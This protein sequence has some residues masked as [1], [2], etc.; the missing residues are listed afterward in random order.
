MK[1]V[2]KVALAQL[3]SYEGPPGLSCLSSEAGIPQENFKYDLHP[4]DIPHGSAVMEDFVLPVYSCFY[5]ISV[6]LSQDD[7]L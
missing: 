7:Q 6:T 2:F 3:F 5:I 4:S 1:S